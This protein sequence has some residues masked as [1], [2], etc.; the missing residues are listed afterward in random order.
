VANPAA[1]LAARLR[2]PD[3][4]LPPHESAMRALQAETLSGPLA[5]AA[6]TPEGLAARVGVEALGPLLLGMAVWL[7]AAAARGEADRYLFCARDGRIMLEAFELIQRRFPPV[8]E[9]RYLAIS[10]QVIYR[11]EAA[12]DPGSAAERFVQNWLSLSPAEA[13]ARWGLDPDGC[14]GA[15]AEAGIADPHAAVAIGDDA[16]LDRLRR[17]FA[18]CRAALTAAAERHAAT[19][20]RYLDLSGAGGGGRACLVDIGWHGSLQTGLG[21]LLRRAGRPPPAGRYLG[22]F[23]RPGEAAARDAAGYLFDADRGPRAAALRASPSLVELLHTARHGSTAG[24]RETAE[25]GVEPVFEARPEE[26]AQFDALIGPTQRAALDFVARAVAMLPSA[27]A[28]LDPAAAFAG[29]DRLLNRPTGPEFATFGALRIA[30]NYG[31]DAAMAA[32]SA[33]DR[34]G[35]RLWSPQDR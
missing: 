24:Y 27:P 9:T 28:A 7:Y 25:G 11:A 35:Y 23:L 6:E 32:L 14:G 20:A 12:A 29:L 15:F 30:A 8:A 13:L 33:R 31:R 19:M 17:L 34:N 18:A 2:L 10:R 16:G 21:K 22:L 3:R 4:P 26:T 1:A 5:T